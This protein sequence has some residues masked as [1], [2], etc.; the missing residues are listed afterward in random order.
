MTSH[1]SS[2]AILDF[3]KLLA[4]RENEQKYQDFLE[5][6]TQFVPREFIQNHG[7]H[8]GLVLRKL[9]MAKD[10][11][12]D[13]FYLSK[14]SADWNGVLV[15]I[16]K[17]HS[18]YFRDNT[19]EFHVDFTKALQQIGQWRGWFSN[20]DN[21][22]A[23]FNATLA[24]VRLPLERNPCHVKYVLVFGRRSE[25][26]KNPTR[27][28]LIYAQER[29][30]FKILSYDSLLED[31]SSKS[32]LYVGVRRNEFIEIISDS[33]INEGMFAWMSPE[34]L[35]ISKKLKDDALSKR[36]TWFHYGIDDD[37]KRFLEMERALPKLKIRDA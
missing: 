35:Q 19:N 20:P 15:E 13:F 36:G 3:K 16:E 27:R 24:H 29:E 1:P 33:F 2:A 34:T 23:F 4:S 31:I 17:A 14:S 28:Q 37:G 12:T 6:N 10:Y 26:E 9:S 21:H 11:T 5:K 7:V 32:E 18:H 8:F 25:F 22:S 30:D